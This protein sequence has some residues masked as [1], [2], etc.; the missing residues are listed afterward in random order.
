MGIKASVYQRVS[1][2]WAMAPYIGALACMREGDDV[3]HGQEG[4][5]AVLLPAQTHPSLSE[6]WHDVSFRAATRA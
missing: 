5:V 4:V 3:I 2:I 1:P 6:G